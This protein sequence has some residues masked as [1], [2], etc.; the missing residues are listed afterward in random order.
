MV[1][2]DL[3][4]LAIYQD[5]RGFLWVGTVNGL[6]RFDG[7][8]FVSYG[9]RQGLTSQ[10]IN[11]ILEDKQGRLWAGT[12]GKQIFRFSDNRFIE[13]PFSDSAKFRYIL[14]LQE[15][16]NGELWVSTDSGMYRFE[17]GNWAKR[18]LVPG[19]ENKICLQILETEK[20]HLL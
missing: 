17:T 19:F 5:S 6:S 20:G 15:L 9:L 3:Y 1:C 18:T 2:P 8:H 4:V 7:K 12:M 14:N 11:H 16:N 10:Y 13:Y